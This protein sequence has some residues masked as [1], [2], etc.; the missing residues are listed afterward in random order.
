V[1]QLPPPSG[2]LAL[3][4]DFGVVSK[5]GGQSENVLIKGINEEYLNE[6]V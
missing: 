3:L 1:F 5:R 6:F 4:A 2:T